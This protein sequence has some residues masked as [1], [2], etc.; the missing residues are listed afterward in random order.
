MKKFTIFL[1]TFGSQMSCE[2]NIERSYLC[3][4]VFFFFFF[5][6]FEKSNVLSIM[7]DSNTTVVS[8]M[9]DFIF[10]IIAFSLS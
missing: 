1:K 8:N 3:F 7:I 2:D 4:F 10:L 6:I 5:F 9:Y